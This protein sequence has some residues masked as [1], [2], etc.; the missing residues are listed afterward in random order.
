MSVKLVRRARKLHWIKMKYNHRR[1]TWTSCSCWISSYVNQILCATNV[2]KFHKI[3]VAVAHQ[4]WNIPFTFHI[5]F[6]AFPVAVRQKMFT[7]L[8]KDFFFKPSLWQSFIE[9]IVWDVKRCAPAAF[10]NPTAVAARR[11]IGI[12]GE[13]QQMS[14]THHIIILCWQFSGFFFFF[15]SWLEGGM[16]GPEWRRS[17]D[18]RSPLQKLKAWC[19][20]SCLLFKADLFH[21]IPSLLISLSPP[22]A[23]CPHNPACCFLAF[24]FPSP[25]SVIPSAPMA[26][27]EFGFGA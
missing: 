24:I 4:E 26:Q 18:R 8:R 13:G 3:L 15:F 17:G 6:P 11:L 5:N 7:L 25:Q 27:R 9:S 22:C 21:S 23:S 20:A 14:Q 10:F 19:L 1:K 12:E 2:G 16:R